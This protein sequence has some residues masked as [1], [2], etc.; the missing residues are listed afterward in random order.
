L[1]LNLNR[2]AKP[3]PIRDQLLH[4][5]LS[6]HP[7]A[8][9]KVVR[10]DVCL[11]GVKVGLGRGWVGGVGIKEKIDAAVSEYGHLFPGLAEGKEG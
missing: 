6:S 1:L 4:G 3:A 7:P 5:T 11:D 2:D 8:R 9:L 10:A